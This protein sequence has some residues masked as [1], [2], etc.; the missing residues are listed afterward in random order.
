[1]AAPGA[2]LFGTPVLDTG[3]G[4]EPFALGRPYQLLAYLACRGTWVARETVAMLFW[5]ERDPSVARANLRFVLV[6]VRRL[7]GVAGFE[8]RIDALRWD[9][10]TDVRRFE[11]AVAD[12]DWARAV[13]CYSV[14]LLEGLDVNAPSPFVE[15]LQL[16]RG[17]LASLWREALAGRLAQLSADPQ[18]CSALA[19]RA[20]QL[21]PLDDVALAAQLQ[22][23]AA[24]GRRDE[25]RRIY[26]GYAQRLAA[27][28]AI[29]PS[30]TLRELSRQI[31]Q[32][33]VVRRPANA[34]GRA[35]EA[36]GLVGR[37]VE[38]GWLRQW[39]S[40][41]R[42]RAVTISGPGGVGKS[43][44]ARAALPILEPA[45]ADGAFW[46][47]LDDVP[48][49]DQVALRCATAIA[50][51]LRGPAAPLSQLVSHLRNTHVLLIFDNAE[52]IAGFGAWLQAL[53]DACRRLKVI[54]TTRV[55]LGPATDRVLPLAGLPSPDPDETEI[56]A[57]RAFD[58]VRLFEARASGVHPHFDG[59]ANAAETAAL[60]RAVDGLPLAIE[61]AAA[62]VRLLPVA[63]I[64]RELERSLDLLVSANASGGDN[65]R[66]TF[67]HSWRLLAPSE[68]DALARLAVFDSD[69]SAESARAVAEAPLPLLAALSDK[70]LLRGDD[71]GRLSLHPLIRQFAREK[72]SQSGPKRS[73]AARARHAQHFLSRLARYNAFHEV[74]QRIAL[75]A[76][77]AEIDNTLAA[78]QW[79]V[80]HRRVD[81][82]E[83]CAGALESYLDARGRHEFGLQLFTTTAC[84]LGKALRG[85]PMACCGIEIAR[86][87][88][89][90]RC[91]EFPEGET[92]ARAALQAAKRAKYAFGLKSSTNTLGLILWRLGRTREA[93]FCLRDVLRRARA[94]GDDA[95][96]PMFAVNLARLEVELGNDEQGER[97]AREALERS[98]G[99]G[100]HEC[101]HAALNE[102]CQILLDQ[103][104]PEQAV[105]LAREGLALC[106]SSG[107]RRNA[108]FFH[109]DLGQ[110]Y[111]LLD[112]LPRATDH[113]RAALDGVRAGADRILEPAC[114]VGLGIIATRCGNRAAALSEL[115]AA[116]RIAQATRS[117][118]VQVEIVVAYAHYRL[119]AGDVE[120]AR[121][122]LALATRH[123]Q[124]TRR[125]RAS[126]TATL[127]RLPSAPPGAAAGDGSTGLDLERALSQLL[128]EAG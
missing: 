61:L 21:D 35:G 79:A 98:R 96:I 74:D 95:A 14:P 2:H 126:A 85:R 86:A 52:H 94:D 76:I 104:R 38:L 47:A 64:R 31:E 49:V 25:A 127:G 34:L 84:S 108:P 42:T 80:E 36:S 87:A 57:L 56:D 88:F 1:M 30:A 118:R 29:E 39:L 44:L 32:A 120:A 66:D 106:E 19:A 37:R 15:W 128:V 55:R 10:E 111:L 99:S 41:D 92:A 78:W 113:F 65:L 105:P 11:R 69:F 102:L 51:E 112:D 13:A 3:T 68:Q 125:Q 89:C 115:Q 4:C 103:R 33:G 22:A 122:L 26:Q 97:L 9:V 27:D 43:T 24:L 48:A 121:S 70:S 124:A 110:A 73:H 123:E 100:N 109:N 54:V 59:N 8:A 101:A 83:Q 71:G 58:A 75:K 40:D 17:R 91:G 23:L 107:F 5:P 117:P 62:W 114:R 67:D 63:E 12:E 116:A 28:L 46:V 77:G 50:L 45:F 81:L 20:L 90:Y 53:L 18:A 119:Q 7:P 16:E 82:L 6:Q 72:L 60:V 93:A